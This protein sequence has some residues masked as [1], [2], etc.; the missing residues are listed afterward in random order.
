MSTTVTPGNSHPAVGAA[1]VHGAANGASR[2]SATNGLVSAA[3][4]D[5][6]AVVDGTAAESRSDE[7]FLP[8]TRYALVDRLTHP[9]AW[10]RTIK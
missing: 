10:D 9:Q 1:A 4:A 7:H 6:P 3:Q 5:A 8:V 2:A